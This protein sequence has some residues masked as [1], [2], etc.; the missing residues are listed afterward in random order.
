MAGV[1]DSKG[2]PAE[3][4][5][6]RTFNVTLD[7]GHKLIYISDGYITFE[8]AGKRLRE[9]FGRSGKFTK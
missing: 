6:S 8:E 9:K 1:S 2:A 7:S 4:R 5:L 3:P